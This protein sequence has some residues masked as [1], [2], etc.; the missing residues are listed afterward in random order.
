MYKNK[1][2]S[3]IYAKDN[4]KPHLMDSIFKSSAKLDIILN[5]DNISFPSQTIGLEK[6]TTVL[7]NDFNKTYE[8]V[9]TLCIEDTL[10]ESKN[11]LQCKWLV[12]MSEKDSKQIRVG[13]G[14]YLWNFDCD[15]ILVDNLTITIEQMNILDKKHT[16]EIFNWINKLSYP[17]C[18][19]EALFKTI[20]NLDALSFLVNLHKT[21]Q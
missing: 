3:Y 11:T 21:Y 13:Y 12:V 1:V 20:P 15:E 8:N 18:T 14:L 17:C 6:I 16:N 10:I 19:S 9:Y 4:N 7:I 5:S 2:T